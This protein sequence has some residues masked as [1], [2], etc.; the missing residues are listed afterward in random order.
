MSGFFDEQ[1]TVAAPEKEGGFFATEDTLG[2][3]PAAPRTKKTHAELLA[4]HQANL[5]QSNPSVGERANALV[6]SA[7]EGLVGGAAGLIPGLAKIGYHAGQALG[8]NAVDQTTGKIPLWEDVKGMVAGIGED[9]GNIS[10]VLPSALGGQGSEMPLEQYKKA[11]EAT[12]RNVGMLA[13][14]EM[15]PPVISMAG[16]TAKAITKA[17]MGPPSELALSIVKPRATDLRFTSADSIAKTFIDE[18]PTGKTKREILENTTAA[19][20]RLNNELTTK[21]STPAAVTKKIK[22][23]D[24]LTAVDE[25]MN[26]AAESNN[27]PLFDRISNFRDSLE[28][29]MAADAEGNIQM[30]E[31]R[32]PTMTPLEANELKKWVDDSTVFTEDAVEKGVNEAKF[33][34]RKALRDGVE[35][36]VPGS[37][38]TLRKTGDLITIERALKRQELR[39]GFDDYLGPAKDTK[40]PL[41]LVP[42]IAVTSKFLGA[43]F[44][45]QTV[46]KWLDSMGTSQRAALQAQYANK[47]VPE[48]AL[49]AP[50]VPAEVP[51]DFEAEYQQKSKQ[52]LLDAYRKANREP[53][54]EAEL[55]TAGASA[56][57][58]VTDYLTDEAQVRETQTLSE[59]NP[60]GIELNQLEDLGVEL[61]QAAPA[62]SAPPV[63]LGKMGYAYKPKIGKLIVDK[64]VAN[65]IAESLNVGNFLGAEFKLE[66]GVS[67]GINVLKKMMPD[68]FDKIPANKPL[69]IQVPKKGFKATA[70]HEGTHRALGEAG[71]PREAW[72]DMM[73]TPEF[74]RAQQSRVINNYLD[75]KRPEEI[76]VNLMS[77]VADKLGLT[78]VQALQLMHDMTEHLVQKY[79][80]EAADTAMRRFIPQKRVTNVGGE[81]MVS[82]P[83]AFKYKRGL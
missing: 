44:L 62:M 1:D 75:V 7:T 33:A 45:K 15:L 55:D 50:P 71:I 21:L 83:E 6:S 66:G 4:Q 80:Q 13:G 54:T 52:M 82:E 31:A 42:G 65:K 76:Y 46:A 43:P 68:V 39:P 3:G 61:N 5:A 49:P 23:Q 12:G 11:G 74:D 26:K 34:A 56:K 73:D 70:R 8:G 32:N 9:I 81:R 38:M 2:E 48:E 20:Q 78:R 30:G 10:A 18:V 57:K 37:A 19:K 64:N 14:A 59:E 22:L 67:K 36:Q 25:V 35:R 51:K 29:H 58:K 17:T 28:H 77:G 41:Q 63:N 47:T 40:G 16:K 69:T 60:L 53:L 72:N 79:G 27:Q 24:A